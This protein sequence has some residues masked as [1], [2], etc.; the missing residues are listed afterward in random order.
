MISGF[1]KGTG[2]I[3]LGIVD[4]GILENIS[5]SNIQI[6]G[7]VVPIF[8]RLGN[9]ARKYKEDAPSPGVGVFRNVIIDNVVAQNVGQIG[10]SITGIPG[11]CIE[12][13]TLSNIKLFYPGNGKVLRKISEVPE[14]ED[15]YPEGTM[16]GDNI[17]YGFFIRHVKGLVMDNI[18]LSFEKNEQRPAIVM[19][20]VEDARINGLDAMIDKESN[21]YELSKSQ[22]VLIASSKVKGSA[23]SFIS[24]ED[25]IS[26]NIFLIN[27]DLRNLKQAVLQ[28]TKGQVELISNINP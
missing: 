10:C 23:S 2:G 13:V 7:P 15:H 18:N 17:S 24:V 9:R 1:P 14:L 22:N 8:L 5:I 26:K 12:N 19:D 16:W 27:N 20:D 21:I 25:T 11:H 6:E 28:K 3:T 4:G